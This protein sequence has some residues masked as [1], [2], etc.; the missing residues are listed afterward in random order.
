MGEIS[1]RNTWEKSVGEISWEK[2]VGEISGR[3]KLGEISGRNTWE[4]IS[5]RKSVGEISG[6]MAAGA[7]GNMR[8]TKCAN[9]ESTLQT[10]SDRSGARAPRPR[11]EL[12][13]TNGRIV[14]ELPELG[15]AAGGGSAAPSSSKSRWA[16]DPAVAPSS[17]GS[18][19]TAYASAAAIIALS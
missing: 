17:R 3:N 13:Q 7:A 4:K 12:L 2:S 6:R 14:R 8:E 16:S 9:A 5:G 15:A 18:R 11:W 19:S 1:G 10:K